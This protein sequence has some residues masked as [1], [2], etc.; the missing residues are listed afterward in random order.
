[1]LESKETESIHNFVRNWK[2]QIVIDVHNYPS[3]RRHLLKKHLIL[4][5]DIFIDIPTN[6]AVIETISDK[7]IKEFI[8]KIKLDLDL[9]GFSCERYVIIQKSGKIRHSTLDVQDARNCLALRYGLFS[10]IL[11]GREPLKKEELKGKN[12]TIFS[13]FYALQSAID[14]LVKNKQ[15]LNFKPHISSKGELVPIQFKYLI[16]NEIIELEVKNSKTKKNKKKKFKN[17]SPDVEISKFITLPTAYG[18]PNSMKKLIK[19]LQKHGF[20]S[21]NNFKSSEYQMYY[22]NIS[23]KSSKKQL[24]KKTIFN[25]ISNFTVFPINQPG[26]RFL[27]MLLEPQSKFGLNRFSELKLNYSKNSEYPIIRI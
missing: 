23:E 27:A 10:I 7:K 18:V 11:E 16:S 26:G 1:L 19:L 22:Y 2:P 14:F 25:Q 13:Q 12:R 15:K 20:S 5:Q 4:N 21:F 6:P 9:K 8:S 3:R 17:F 24:K